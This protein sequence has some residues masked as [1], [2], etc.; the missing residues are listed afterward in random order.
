MRLA[1]LGRQPGNGSRGH[2]SLWGHQ[3]G[4]GRRCEPACE[5]PGPHLLT[6]APPT[7][8]AAPA[9]PA[10]REEGPAFLPTRGQGGQGPLQRGTP[11]PIDSAGDGQPT[12]GL[13]ETKPQACQMGGRAGCAVTCLC[14][15]QTLSIWEP[16]NVTLFGNGCDKTLDGLAPPS[17]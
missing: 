3:G 1:G 10:P 13:H 5:P 16:G 8:P 9:P 2:R 14:P 12:T 17:V 15:S 11:S 6:A 7:C 4:P